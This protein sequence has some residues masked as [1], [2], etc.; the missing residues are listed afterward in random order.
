VLFDRRQP[1]EV[2]LH[3]RGELVAL[4]LQEPELRFLASA[5]AGLPGPRSRAADEARPFRCNQD[6]DRRREQGDE[7]PAH[8]SI[9]DTSP[10]GV[11]AGLRYSRLVRVAASSVLAIL[12]RAFHP[13]GARA[14]E[15][16]SGI[17]VSAGDRLR[18][19]AV[20][21][22]SRPHPRVMGSCSSSSPRDRSRGAPRPA[23]PS[24]RATPRDDP[25]LQA[26]RRAVGA[27]APLVGRQF[28]LL[29]APSRAGAWLDVP[30]A[31][32]RP[33]APRRHARER[34]RRLL[35]TVGR[36]R[37]V[38]VPVREAGVYRQF[39]SLHPTTMTQV[40]AVR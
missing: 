38:L 14:A 2:A 37:L 5:R 34:A 8:V 16:A 31:L 18:L 32:W 35:L 27:C 25:T 3:A 21:E 36:Q 15:T 20:Y 19:T 23:Q 39:C 13:G 4:G 24:L 10:R 11:A 7:E 17:P 9:L 30:L 40:V 12:G 6:D 29:R 28:R 26:A 22:N 1:L 33:L